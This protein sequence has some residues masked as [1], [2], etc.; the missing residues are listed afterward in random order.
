M[1]KKL[2]PKKALAVILSAAMAFSPAIT[3]SATTSEEALL[4]NVPAELVEALEKAD[5][6]AKES[7]E[8]EKADETEEVKEADAAEVT[9]DLPLFEQVDPEEEGLE[10]T[11]TKEV[12]EAEV[13][14]IQV[15]EPDPDEQTRVIIVM[16][17]DSVLDAGFDTEDL[18][19]NGAA[20]NMSENIIAEQE[21][22][23][24]ALNQTFASR[25]NTSG[26]NEEM[27]DPREMSDEEREAFFENMEQRM[28]EMQAKRTERE[29]ALKEYDKVIKTV[30]DKKQF[31]AYKKDRTREDAA[32]RERQQGMG[33]FPGG[34]GGFGGPGGGFGGPGGGFGGPG[35]F[36]GGF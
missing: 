32:N 36:G 17:G 26:M 35:G 11:A 6:E 22:Q 2:C 33:G 27:G 5:A 13:T 20:M 28:Q 19:E 8:A 16:E 14:D 15:E 4:E 34:P 29:K 24:M 23:V 30:L 25:L 1:K 7:E 31:K 9:E 10:L 12:M 21:Q 3:A 18:A